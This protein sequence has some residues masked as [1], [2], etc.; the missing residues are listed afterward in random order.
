MAP[1]HKYKY[2]YI[3]ENTN[4]NES[5]NTNVNVNANIDIRANTNA[6]INAIPLGRT[7]P[8]DKGHKYRVM[9]KPKQ[10]RPRRMCK[11]DGIGLGLDL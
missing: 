1:Q 4:T 2:S 5:T 7:C 10:C 6:K 9:I 11:W 8:N 3:D